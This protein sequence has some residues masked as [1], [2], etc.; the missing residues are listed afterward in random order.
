VASNYR[1]HSVCELAYA[2]IAE[3]YFGRLF[4]LI[5][6]DIVSLVQNKIG[7]VGAD[8]QESVCK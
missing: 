2:D 7:N 1:V 8:L 5:V 4:I 6:S 3:P